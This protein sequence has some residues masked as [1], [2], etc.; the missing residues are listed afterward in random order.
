MSN[1]SRRQQLEKVE[2]EFPKPPDPKDEAELAEAERW[3][4]ELLERKVVWASEFLRTSTEAEI[5]HHE[6]W[7]SQREKAF[8]KDCERRGL[9]FNHARESIWDFLEFCQRYD[10]PSPPLEEPKQE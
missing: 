1:L 7:R 2:K 3:F 5:Q 9:V 8:Q 4:K 6:M 10:E